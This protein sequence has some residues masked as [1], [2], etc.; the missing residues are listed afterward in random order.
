MSALRVG[1]DLIHF[2]DIPGRDDD[3]PTL[4]WAHGFLLEASAYRELIS[5]LPDFRHVIVDHR[6]HGR[7]A[8]IETEATIERMAADL[9]AVVTHLGID[10]LVYVGHSM[11]SAIGWRFTADHPEV[12]VAGVSIA[13]IPVTGKLEESR[14][15][16]LGMIDMAGDTAALTEMIGGLYKHLDVVGADHLRSV[17][18]A[19]AVVPQETIR[20]IVTN[21]FHVDQRA[22]ALP[23]LTQPWLFIASSE[24]ESEP[25]AHQTERAGLL[26]SATTVVLEGEGHMAPQESPALVA[27]AILDF[28]S[29]HPAHGATR[30]ASA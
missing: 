17:G 7:S 6:G 23:H 4:L 24:D 3:A 8:S 29:T 14:P 10:R 9:S 13:G 19:A 15:W 5:L 22:D 18:E 16:V 30:V 21:Q 2:D 1:N 27:D 25:A 20:E 12:V 26:P 11:G 28:L